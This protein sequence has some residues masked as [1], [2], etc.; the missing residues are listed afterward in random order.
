MLRFFKITVNREFIAFYCALSIILLFQAN[1]IADDKNRVIHGCIQKDDNV[2]CPKT[3][4]ANFSESQLLYYSN[5]NKKLVIT[6]KELYNKAVQYEK[7]G[8]LNLCQNL[9]F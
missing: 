9:L 2:Y 7:E 3:M 6:A 4:D 5:Q 1:L 8:K